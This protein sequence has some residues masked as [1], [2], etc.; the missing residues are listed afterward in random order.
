MI[1]HKTFG[2]HWLVILASCPISRLA[3]RAGDQHIGMVTTAAHPQE[4]RPV[5]R[6]PSV[7]CPASHQ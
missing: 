3:T 1:R 2:P 4:D 7:P 6:R 5:I